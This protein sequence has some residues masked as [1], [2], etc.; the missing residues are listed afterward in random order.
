MVQ[1]KSP[2]KPTRFSVDYGPELFPRIKR[3]EKELKLTTAA[4]IRWLINRGLNAE[5]EAGR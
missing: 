1:K 4:T 2:K 5:E 3:A